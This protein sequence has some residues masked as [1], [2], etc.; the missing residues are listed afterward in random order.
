MQAHLSMAEMF[1]I[2]AFR[3]NGLL[4]WTDI[5]SNGV[6]SIQWASS[7]TDEWN[8]AWSK[9]ESLTATGGT[10]SVNIPM[11]FRITY[12]PFFAPHTNIVLVAGGGQPL[13]PPYDF[14]M[15]K[16]E[17][18]NCEW[19]DFLN[20]AQIH[21]N[22]IRGTNMFF[23]SGGNVY[24][25][26]SMSSDEI[27]F[28]IASSDLIYDTG[29]PVG[30]RYSV[31]LVPSNRPITGVSWYG[32]LKYCNWLT[33][34]A[35][36]GEDQRCYSEGT[37]G[38]AWHPSGIAYADW[39]DNFSPPE[40]LAW[41]NNFRGFRLP[42]DDYCL[43]ASYFNEWYKAAAWNGQTNTTYA[44]GRN[45]IDGQDACWMSSSHPYRM[46][47]I[48]TTPVGYY[49]GTS[50][51]G[52]FQTRASSNFFGLYDLSGNV[53]EWLSDAWGPNDPDMRTRGGFWSA[54]FDYAATDYLDWDR[55]KSTC[56][57]YLGFRIV[58]T[59]P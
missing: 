57:N 41:L 3:S 17:V 11:Y 12:R 36:R 47:T 45:S 31:W 15:S 34:V 56:A 54:N 48:G 4:M 35:G 51:G 24:M 5:Y 33:L 7:P 19:V 10:M 9:L 6:Y 14:Y 25:N 28:S 26:S 40:R 18:Q 16:Y 38:S 29:N 2:E 44:Y 27:L 53:A 58:T 37:S 30:A 20:D 49:D 21:T 52:S 23:A 8:K 42:M 22:D 59:G 32:S 13:G 43:R 1:D 50:H 55:Q 39:Y 46:Y